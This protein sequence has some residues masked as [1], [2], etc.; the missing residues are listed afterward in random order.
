M[1]EPYANSLFI[2]RAAVILRT[3]INPVHYRIDPQ[4]RQFHYAFRTSFF[5]F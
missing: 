5:A 3:A 4:T 1:R 2:H